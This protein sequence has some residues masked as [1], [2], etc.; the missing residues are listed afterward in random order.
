MSKFKKKS[1]GG[2]PAISTSSLPDI[3]FMLLFFFMVTT[4]TRTNDLSISIS[5][6]SATETGILDDKTPTA[7]INIGVP[8]KALQALYGDNQRIQLNL[9]TSTTT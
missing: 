8:V 2:T 7:Y 4:K 1:D 5:L 9:K 6:P 3:V